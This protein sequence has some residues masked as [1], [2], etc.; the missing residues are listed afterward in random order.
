MKKLTA[1]LMPIFIIITALGGCSVNT[2][3]SGRLSIVCTS[4]AA[5]DW[6]CEIAGAAKTGGADA[7]DTAQSLNIIMLP[8]SGADLHSYQATAQDIVNIS[9]CDLIVRTGGVSEG[10]IDKALK[11]NK[12]TKT[13]NF[14]QLLGANTLKTEHTDHDHSNGTGDTELE[15]DEHAW[16]SVKNAIV[17][18]D[19]ISSALIELDSNNADIYRENCR[20]YTEK[21]RA[22]DARFEDMAEKSENNT[23]LF[24][25][26][27]PFRYLLN[28][29]KI[30]F[31]AAF[32][33]CST[34]TETS[35]DTIIFLAEKTNSLNLDYIMT[36]DSSQSSVAK[37]VLKN[38]KRK[39]VQ[40][41]SL[42]SMQSCGKKDYDSG[43]RYIS[44][45]EANLEL[46]ATALGGEAND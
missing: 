15:T 33:G 42:D 46:I 24:A 35:F 13:V 37:T 44:V 43:K 29:Y 6:V 40:I 23:L 20:K 38:T 5:Y 1:I 39:D 11:E 12:N 30:E 7:D 22:V 17:F 4:F 27:F 19:A 28:D 32:P 41:L 14:L 36:I 18:C 10:W 26:R 31:F 45:M 34:E 25:D 2:A 9:A 3:D 21:L 16:L 8:D